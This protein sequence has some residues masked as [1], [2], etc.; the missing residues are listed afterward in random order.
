M[1]SSAAFLSQL[2][3][4]NRKSCDVDVLELDQS[5]GRLEVDFT[6]RHRHAWPS[7]RE[8]QT[9][10]RTVLGPIGTDV[11]DLA[12]LLPDLTF[13]A[14]RKLYHM[15]DLNAHEANTRAY[16]AEQRADEAADRVATKEKEL[17]ALARELAQAQIDLRTAV[18]RETLARQ[19]AQAACVQMLELDSKVRLA[20]NKA[21]GLEATSLAK[22]HIYG[23]RDTSKKW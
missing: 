13:D 23:S 14:A 12:D 19:E 5:N 9:Q 18:E 8:A 16:Q 11:E 7:L 2:A 20:R 6:L 17:T 3:L 10:L 1:R 21:N 22:P 15:M 4:G